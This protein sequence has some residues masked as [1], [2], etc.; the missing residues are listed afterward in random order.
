MILLRGDLV[1]LA[2]LAFIAAGLAVDSVAKA[3]FGIQPQTLVGLA[4]V[5]N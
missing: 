2:A 1:A 4:V 5:A 3:I